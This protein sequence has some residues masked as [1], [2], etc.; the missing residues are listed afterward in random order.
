MIRKTFLNFIGVITGVVMLICLI[1]TLEAFSASVP[2]VTDD[3]ILI[4]IPGPM[5]GGAAIYS[6]VSDLHEAMYLEWGQNIH[7]RKIKVIREDDAGNPV[8]AV[9]TAKKLLY[10]DNVFLIHGP[11]MSTPA[12]AMKPSVQQAGTP[13]MLGGC[14]ADQI[15]VPTVKN[16]FN[17][18]FI[19]SD[20]AK[21]MV[22]FT[23]TI[24]GVKRIGTIR[25]T[26]EWSVGY[27]KSFTEYLKEKYN[28]TPVVNVVTETGVTDV[29]PQVLKLKDA[30][31]DVVIL[32]IYIPE[33]TAFL[34]EA[35][36]LGL[37][38]PIVAGTG[39]AVTD[40][41]ENLKSLTPL[42][43][44][45]SAYWCKYPLDHPKIQVYRDLFKKYQ[46]AKKFDALVVHNPSGALVIMDALKKCGRDLTQEKFID[47][48]ETYY[49]N[50]EPDNYIGTVPLTFTK[51]N[52]VGMNRLV[53]STIATGNLEIVRTYQDYE[54]LMKK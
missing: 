15:V 40:Q 42:K 34:K 9:A 2:G 25:H 33:T 36:K 18:V 20:A 41:Y 26:D 30:D 37:N 16:I 1:N 27:Y 11:V 29:T 32:V 53:M 44:Y 17:P 31:V 51:T 43:K 28:M 46:P 14:P 6:K 38:V 19:S 45:F 50:W 21:T 48:L 39:S 49:N 47:A 13:W 5:T 24:P 52:H 3:T 7:G 54:K 22:D 12:L 23:M 4:G 10:T 8:K 35:N